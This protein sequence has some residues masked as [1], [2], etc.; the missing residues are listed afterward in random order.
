MAERDPLEG[1]GDSLAQQSSEGSSAPAIIG[2]CENPSRAVGVQRVLAEKRDARPG[3]ESS[4][5]VRGDDRLDQNS[6]RFLE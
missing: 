4:A 6:S 2:H 1:A 5:A 3:P